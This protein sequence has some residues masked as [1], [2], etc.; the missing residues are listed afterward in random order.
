MPNKIF[1]TFPKINSLF[2]IEKHLHLCEEKVDSE[3]D[4]VH[5]TLNDE[6]NRVYNGPNAFPEGL[7]L[8]EG[9]KHL[10]V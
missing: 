2:C 1:S 10:H 9:L 6:K 7:Y 8:I 5:I 4:A 3:I